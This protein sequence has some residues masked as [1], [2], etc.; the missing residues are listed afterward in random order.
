MQ[1]GSGFHSVD[2]QA[3]LAELLYTYLG[4]PRVALRDHHLLIGQSC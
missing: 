4:E 3:E 2:L 1:V